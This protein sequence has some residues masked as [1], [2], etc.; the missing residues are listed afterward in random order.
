M[1]LAIRKKFISIIISRSIK[2]II[3]WY[4]F[5]SNRKIERQKTT[6]K[7]KSLNSVKFHEFKKKIK[8]IKIIIVKLVLTFSIKNTIGCKPRDTKLKSFKN[9]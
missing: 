1:L 4:Q 3:E 9:I 7:K 8:I 6:M 5:F 2:I